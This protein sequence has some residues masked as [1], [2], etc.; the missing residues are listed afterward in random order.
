MLAES[1]RVNRLVQNQHR[2]ILPALQFV[3]HDGHLRLA[4]CIGDERV[5]HA[6]GFEPDSE[7]KLIA[8]HGL[9]VVGAVV[10]S[11]RIKIRADAL[12]RGG[13]LRAAIFIER[14][15]ALEEHVLKQM[16]RAGVADRLVARAD[17]IEHQTGDDRRD[18]VLNE[19]HFQA[20]RQT[21]FADAVGFGDERD[22]GRQL[23]FGS[24][25]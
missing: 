18:A 21:I 5:A 12:E 9:E 25:G 8:R 13:D 11:G 22:A 6:V 16:R 4:I 10:P 7:F 20:V 17:A 1:G 3:A 19:Q 15:R 2:L 23:F 14:R 24:C